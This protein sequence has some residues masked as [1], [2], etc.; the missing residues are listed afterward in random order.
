MS[1]QSGDCLL[2]LGSPL[3]GTEWEEFLALVYAERIEA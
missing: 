1:N 2:M 3:S